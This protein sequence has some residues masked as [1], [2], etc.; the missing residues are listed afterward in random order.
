MNKNMLAATL[1]ALLLTGVVRAEDK[2]APT[3]KESIMT[4]FKNL[5]S[6]LSQSAVQGERKKARGAGSVAAVRGAGQYSELADP[7]E[8]SLK[9]DARAKR[10]KKALAEDAEFE[11]GVSLVLAGKT[12]EGIKALEAFKVKYPKSRSLASVDEA[13]AKAKALAAEKAESP[14]AEPAK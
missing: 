5:K 3:A 2:P 14:K 9:G 11:K 10:A 1:S 12:D 8:T 4:F 7:N 6:T 13:I